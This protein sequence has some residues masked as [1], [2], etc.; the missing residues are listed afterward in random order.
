M[1]EQVSEDVMIKIVMIKRLITEPD[2]WFNTNKRCKCGG[3]IFKCNYDKISG[4]I[5]VICRSCNEE[6]IS[7]NIL[8]YK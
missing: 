5:D 2:I 4:G 1:P 8:E 3:H 7:F 6:F